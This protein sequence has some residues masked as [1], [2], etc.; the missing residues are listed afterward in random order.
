VKSNRTS[1]SREEIR[2][3]LDFLQS[4]LPIQPTA[5]NIPYILPFEISNNLIYQDDFVINL[6]RIAD[7]IGYYLLVLKKVMVLY[8]D[9]QIDGNEKIYTCTSNGSILIHENYNEVAGQYAKIDPD[10]RLITIHKKRG[11][12]VKHII[13]I[14]VHEMMHH[15]LNHFNIRKNDTPENEILTDIAS[16]YVGMGHLLLE[17]YMTIDWTTDHWEKDDRRGHTLHETCIG[18]VNTETL[19]D[20]I[21]ISTE[22]RGLRPNDTINSIISSSDRSIIQRKLLNYR[23][24]IFKKKMQKIAENISNNVRSKKYSKAKLKLDKLLLKHDDLIKRRQH[25]D[26]II[27]DKVDAKDGIKI[28]NIINDISAGNYE[29]QLLEIKSVFNTIGLSNTSKIFQRLHDLEKTFDDGI[30]LF[31]KYI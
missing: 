18:Y 21:A 2:N 14:L 3:Y 16:T 10:V 13:G 12:Q 1:L 11:Y 22:L 23:F 15:Y 5:T 7:H 24:L 27:L 8:Y 19:Q 6:Q 28:V 26:K 17:A 4:K 30:R 25:I 20:A 9:V 29:N 31:S